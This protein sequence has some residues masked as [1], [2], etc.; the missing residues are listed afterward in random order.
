MVYECILEWQIVTYHF[1]VTIT[2]TSNL[3][4][5]LIMFEEYLLCNLRYES[6]M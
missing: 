6:Q 3:V 1:R 4:L 2:L 5:R